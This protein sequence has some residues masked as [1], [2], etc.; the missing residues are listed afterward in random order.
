METK[1]TAE[2]LFNEENFV[3]DKKEEHK[4]GYQYGLHDNR[5]YTC[6]DEKIIFSGIKCVCAGRDVMLCCRRFETRS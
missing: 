3:R 2:E 5:I 6:D 4:R 1:K